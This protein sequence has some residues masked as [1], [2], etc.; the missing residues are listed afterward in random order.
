MINV[1]CPITLLA[2]FNTPEQ[3]QYFISLTFF[4]N[5]SDRIGELP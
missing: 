1:I 2:I 5:H 4:S 3:V